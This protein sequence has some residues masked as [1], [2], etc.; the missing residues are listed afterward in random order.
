MNSR[1]PLF[2]RPLLRLRRCPRGKVSLG[3]DRLH[4]G[5]L[6]SQAEAMPSVV[7]LSAAVE[8]YGVRCTAIGAGQSNSGRGVVHDLRYA[9][10][11]CFRENVGG[12]PGTDG[13]GP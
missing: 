5:P 7:K 2:W 4:A 13:T 12:I 3:K 1:R 6:S 11:G 10:A 8:T 9:P